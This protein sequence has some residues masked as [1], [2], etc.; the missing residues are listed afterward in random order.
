MKSTLP[1]VLH[2][3]LGQPMLE[4]VLR[5]AAPLGPITVVIGP[6]MPAAREL[7]GARGACVVQDPPLG[8]AHAL[9]QARGAQAEHV[10]VTCGDVPLLRTE[11]LR[12]LVRAR[13][14]SAAAAVLLTMTLSQPGGYGR[15]VRDADGRRVLRVVEEVACSE[16]ERAIREV[17]AGVYCFDGHWLWE[18]L[19]HVHPNPHNGEY[20]LTDLVV[21]AHQSGRAVI[22]LPVEDA[23]E[24]LG[25]NTRADLAQAEAALRRRINLRHMLNGV[26][27]AHPETIYI[28]PDVQ[29]APDTRIEPNTHLRGHT[30]IGSGCVIGPNSTLI[31]AQIGDRVVITY[32]VL[33]DAQVEDDADV[34]PF[35]HL[36]RGA[37]VGRRAHVGNFAE[38]KNSTLGADSAMGHFSYLGDAT[39][40]ERTNLG[41]GMIT[42]NYDGQR[43]HHTHI[44]SDVFIGSDT[45]LVAPVT[46]GD[47][48]RTG[49]GAVV[50]R[51]VPPGVTVV[52]V[53]ARRLER[54][55]D[56]PASAGDA[57]A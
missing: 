47:G 42:C 39:V 3:L 17:N 51:D 1:K 46:V 5:A 50:T 37:R 53:P 32:S 12:A 27:L 33:E 29:I 43:K 15:I 52:G 20:F 28:E 31:N 22:G 49:A 7:V 45:M 30:R 16:A 48:A 40:G 21:I 57:S 18:A 36:R 14:E 13:V 11:T 6:D 2:P 55:Q 44:G 41:A 38:I 19:E 34:G 26:T 35:A 56:A 4:H 10:L 25:V 9:L 23:E 54:T 24:C 8:T